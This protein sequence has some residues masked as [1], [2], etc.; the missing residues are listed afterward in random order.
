MVC[1][2][3]VRVTRVGVSRE[4]GY[5]CRVRVT[6]VGVSLLKVNGREKE[7]VG[8]SLY[9]KGHSGWS[10]SREKGVFPTSTGVS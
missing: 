4:R 7:R 3:T 1:D 9:G 2:C 5:P 10:K 6:R 8:V